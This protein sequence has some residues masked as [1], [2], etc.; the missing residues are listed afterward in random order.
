MKPTG[1][2]SPVGGKCQHSCLSGPGWID[3]HGYSGEP[4]VGACRGGGHSQ[5]ETRVWGVSVQAGTH[6]PP[7][8]HHTDLPG[9][10]VCCRNPSTHVLFPLLG[11]LPPSPKA[12]LSTP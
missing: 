10:L 4:G 8:P 11:R 12:L 3:C 7:L 2:E 1:E 5:M 9:F 6:A